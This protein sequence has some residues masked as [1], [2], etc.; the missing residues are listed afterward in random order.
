M[1][2]GTRRTLNLWATETMGLTS[3][4]TCHLIRAVTPFDCILCGENSKGLANFCP[5]CTEDLPFINQ[6]CQYCGVET[7]Q[8]PEP[9][10]GSC[11]L[12]KPVFN[13]CIAVMSYASPADKLISQFKFNANFAAGLALGEVLAQKFKH[14]CE[15]HG[16]P[17]AIIPVPLHQ[18]RLQ[19]RGFNQALELAKQ[20]SKLTGI[21][22]LDKKLTRIKNTLPQ[23]EIKR[24]RLRKSNLKKAFVCTDL[25]GNAGG[26][27]VALVDDVVTT[28]ATLNEA[29]RALFI[30]G[31]ER[32][33]C[34]CVARASR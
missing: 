30:A 16:Y 5:T 1:K 27:R 26:K 29:A 10:C 32:V 31:A 17:D 25:P 33:D 20:L 12:R 19:E 8:S 13:R 7:S 34:F 15:C 21:P 3:P 24:A 6:P 18:R 4:N 9:F 22:M 2:S 14:H 11:T 23:T 28:G